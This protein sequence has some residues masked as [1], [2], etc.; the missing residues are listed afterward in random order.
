M[1]SDLRVWSLWKHD[2]IALPL[3]IRPIAATV[4]K[5]NW[6]I[7]D[8][9]DTDIRPVPPLDFAVAADYEG[10]LNKISNSPNVD[11]DHTFAHG[12]HLPILD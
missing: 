7:A 4:A 9:V 3:S 12:H 10:T 2:E 1:Y 8:T 6:L 11:D 5:Q